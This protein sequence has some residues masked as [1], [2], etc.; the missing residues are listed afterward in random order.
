MNLTCDIVINQGKKYL[1]LSPLVRGG[2]CTVEPMTEES[3]QRLERLFSVKR[4]TGL[5]SPLLF[6]SREENFGDGSS[7]RKL[8]GTANVMQC[9]YADIQAATGLKLTFT[10]IKDL[11]V[12]V[13]L[14][15]GI[16]PFVVARRAGYKHLRSV[17]QRMAAFFRAV[18]PS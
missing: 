16:E 10:D 9:L 12:R 3:S 13:L 4:Q 8:R 7:C 14:E 18:G 5:S 6:P 11:V 1:H 17:E 15:S 2:Q